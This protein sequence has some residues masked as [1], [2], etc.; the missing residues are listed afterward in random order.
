MRPGADRYADRRAKAAAIELAQWRIGAIRERFVDSDVKD[1]AARIG[2]ARPNAN[3]DNAPEQ[4]EVVITFGR[5]A[6]E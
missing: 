6:K 3:L 1:I 2:G 4:S 5:R